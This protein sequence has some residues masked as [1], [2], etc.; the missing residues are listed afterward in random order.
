MTS[1]EEK[2]LFI[3]LKTEYYNAFCDG[4]KPEEFRKYGDRWNERTCR[5]G[6]T[7]LP[8]IEK[9]QKHY[10]KLGRLVVR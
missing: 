5:S 1:D 8:V 9:Q 2:P 6:S 4:T 7:E 10:R 3:P